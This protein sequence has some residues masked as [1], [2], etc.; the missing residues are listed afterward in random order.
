MCILFSQS[1]LGD[2]VKHY[3]PCENRT[4]VLQNIYGNKYTFGHIRV[5]H[6]F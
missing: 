4:D 1:L 6:I 3:S 2:N 5:D